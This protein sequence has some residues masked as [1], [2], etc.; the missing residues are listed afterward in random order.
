LTIGPEWYFLA[1]SGG[2]C[3][4]IAPSPGLGTILGDIFMQAFNVYFDRA[5]KQIGFAPVK[6]CQGTASIN[7]TGGDHQA[8]TVGSSY[9]ESL[10]VQVR[11]EDGSPAV[12]LIVE[13]TT[14]SGS[15]T[16]SLVNS[17]FLSSKFLVQ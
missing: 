14:S 6:D 7:I 16:P 12:G 15:G 5:N 1:V 13:F 10:V 17:N 4:G 8:G 2:Y 9:S 11:F 3:F